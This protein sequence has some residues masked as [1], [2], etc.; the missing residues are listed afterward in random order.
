MKKTFLSLIALFIA[1]ITFAYDIEIDGIYYNLNEENETAEVT[2]QNF[3]SNNYSGVTTINIPLSF[4]YNNKTYKITYISS[5]A[6]YK[7]STLTTVTI[8]NSVTVIGGRAFSD[9][10]SLSS[11]TIPNSV[12]TIGNWAFDG[13]AWLNNQ[14]DGCV[15]INNC[16]YTYKGEMPENTHINVKEGTTKIC[17]FAFLDCTTLSSITIPNSVTYIGFGTFSNCTSLTSITIPDNIT[18]IEEEAFSNCSSLT[19]IAI[20]N[21]VT[22]IKKSTFYNCTSLTSITIPN[23]VTSIDNKAFYKCSS[24]ASITIP[25]SITSVGGEAFYGTTWLDN[26][27]DGCIYINNCLYT[28]KGEMPTNTHIDIKKSTTQICDCAFYNCSALTSITIPNN[29]TYIGNSAFYKCSSLTSTSIPNNI[30]YIGD[31]AFAFCTSLTSFEI[32]AQTPPNINQMT[33]FK[34]PLSTEIKVPCSAIAN[35]QVADYWKDFTNYVGILSK[36]TVLS[37]DKTMGCVEINKQATCEDVTSEIEAKPFEG[38]EF[39]KW[40]DDNTENPRTIY[41]TNDTTITAEFKV[42]TSTPTENTTDSQYKIYTTNNTIHF[43]NVEINYQI[44]TATGQLIYTGND[45][46]ITLS[47]GIY[48]VTIKDKTQKIAL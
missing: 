19:S 27:P 41:V 12:T 34:V 16:L 8:P 38:Y 7:C 48:I 26:Q 43:E 40:S 15:Y 44:H 23:S 9:C 2:Y 45:A 36:L 3:Y 42:A 29:V 46:S 5:F 33:F 47:H 14:P 22:S 25:N 1:T 11:I 31:N 13:T 32:L 35:Y 6:F 20:P 28:Y 24:L 21:N 18:S 30:T 10:T 37:N 4:T 17:D 39:V